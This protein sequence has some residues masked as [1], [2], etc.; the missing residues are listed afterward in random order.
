MIT[1][2]DDKLPAYQTFG[3]KLH[4][5]FDERV[6]IMRNIDDTERTGYEY[7]TA[8]STVFANRNDLIEEIIRSKYTLSAELAVMNNQKEREDSYAEFQAFRAQAKVLAD[9]WL[10]TKIQQDDV[11]S[12]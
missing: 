5:N 10:S 12:E 9:G 11:K 2:T 3:E 8:V 7:T 1:L 6:V 4:I